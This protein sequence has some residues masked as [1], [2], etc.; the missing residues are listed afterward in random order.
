MKLEKS[1]CV[2][3]LISLPLWMSAANLL[4][5]NDLLLATIFE[6]WLVI[7]FG[8][9]SISHQSNSSRTNSQS[10]CQVLKLF[11]CSPGP[12][13]SMILSKAK[14]LETE[15]NDKLMAGLAGLA[16]GALIFGSRR[17]PAAPVGRNPRKKTRRRTKTRTRAKTVVI[18]KNPRRPKPKR[19]RPQRDVRIIVI[20]QIFS[21]LRSMGALGSVPGS[22]RRSL[23]GLSLVDARK[24][25][26]YVHAH[27][28]LPRPS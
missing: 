25:L 3:R 11:A 5:R 26:R 19:K 1:I 23:N 18:Y 22:M 27:G 20:N 7:G 14:Q 28:R 24:T 10:T 2:A 8:I 9:T 15:M 17:S 13:W 4:E 21:A 16:V 12:R 6:A